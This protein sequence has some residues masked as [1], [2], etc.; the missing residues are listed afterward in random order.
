LAAIRK[1]DNLKG[2]KLAT[3]SA[4]E[5]ARTFS[6][7]VARVRYRGEEFVVE[8]GGEPVCRISSAGPSPHFTAADLGRL[9]GELPLP[10]EG[11]VAEVK[12]AIRKQP[13][14]SKVSPWER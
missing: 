12:A 2:M 4:T 7:V 6:A 1:S 9:L 10:D 14:T 5:A 13:K 8:K 11:F 3:I